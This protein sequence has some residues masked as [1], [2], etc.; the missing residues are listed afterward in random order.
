MLKGELEDQGFTSKYLISHD[1][2]KE[3]E[4][5]TFIDVTTA[6]EGD[7]ITFYLV[8]GKVKNSFKGTIIGTVE[9]TGRRD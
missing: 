2:L 7:I 1:K 8:D 6:S 5:L 3:E 9:E 4:Y